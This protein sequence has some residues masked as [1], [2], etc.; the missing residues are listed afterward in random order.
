MGNIKGLLCY[1]SIS[2]ND[3]VEWLIRG[4][5]N[6]SFSCSEPFG[7]F[8]RYDEKSCWWRSAH[9]WL[10]VAELFAR[11]QR[12]GRVLVVLGQR[13]CI[14]TLPVTIARA[15]GCGVAYLPGFSMH[16]MTDLH[17]G[18]GET[19]ARDA[20]VIADAASAVPHVL[21]SINPEE[22]VRAEP[23]MVWDATTTSPR[24]LAVPPIGCADC[25]RP[26]TRSR[27]RPGTT[28]AAH[29]AVLA[30]LQ[31]FGLRLSS[32]RPVPSRSCRSCFRRPRV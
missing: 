21:H 10:P 14:G 8:F 5:K 22:S 1:S 26:S 6:F 20:Y 15:C 12:K 23:A 31:T 13:A 7:Y 18:M 24:T 32:P 9:G 19:D 11:L 30:M 29:P 28:P 25:S 27:T 3:C 17:P 4:A 2:T 16:R